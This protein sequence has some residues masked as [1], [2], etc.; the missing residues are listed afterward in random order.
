MVQREKNGKNQKKRHLKKAGKG[1]PP[2]C[3]TTYEDYVEY[4]VKV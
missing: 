1:I 2:I 3:T 4:V